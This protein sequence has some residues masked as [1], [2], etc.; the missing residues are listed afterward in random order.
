MKPAHTVDP[1]VLA[2]ELRRALRGHGQ[3]VDPLRAVDALDWKLAG[4][5]PPGFDHSA[6]Q[7]LAHMVYWQDRY[8]ARLAGEDAPTPPHDAEGW[9]GPAAPSS[10]REWLDAVDAFRRGLAAADAAVGAAPLGDT[11]PTL[12]GK[13]RLGTLNG[14]ALHN[15]YHAG[16]LAQLRKVLGAWPPPGGGD[17]W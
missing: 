10:E 11:G 16:Q 15:G 4:R 2:E 3:F 6:L 5:T 9:P 13:T 17:S 1:S 7:L 14:L 12:A 8:L